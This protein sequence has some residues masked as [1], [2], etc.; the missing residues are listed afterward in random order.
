MG[1]LGSDSSR[2][3][4]KS[5][6]ILDTINLG[7]HTSQHTVAKHMQMHDRPGAEQQNEFLQSDSM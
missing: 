3:P 7:E 1:T 2:S 4:L 6:V 5:L